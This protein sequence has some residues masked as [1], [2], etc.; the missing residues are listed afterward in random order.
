MRLG[1]Y[2][3]QQIGQSNTMKEYIIDLISATY[4]PQQKKYF[5]GL[6]GQLF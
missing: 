5:N 1:L 2:T 6:I 4:F 3:H